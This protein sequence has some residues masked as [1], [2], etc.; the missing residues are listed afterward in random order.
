MKN[1]T[2]KVEKVAEILTDKLEFSQNPLG[3]EIRVICLYC[4]VKESLN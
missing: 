3:I 1:L 4:I 2:V